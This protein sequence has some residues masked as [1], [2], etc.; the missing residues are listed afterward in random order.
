MAPVTVSSSG[1]GVAHLPNQKHKIVTNRGCNFTVMV[2]GKLG[3]FFIHPRVIKKGE[4]PID[5][6]YKET[7]T[8]TYT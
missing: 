7:D 6:L 2:C 8:E 5:I 1:I 3:G 4:V